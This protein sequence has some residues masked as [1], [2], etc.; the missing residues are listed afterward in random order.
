MY[1]C[2]PVLL[3]I[4]NLMMLHSTNDYDWVPL[5]V[6]VDWLPKVDNNRLN[7]L[8]AK[9][10]PTMSWVSEHTL[11]SVTLFLFYSGSLPNVIWNVPN[12]I[13]NPMEWSDPNK[14]TYG[15]VCQV[16]RLDLAGTHRCSM[17]IM[18]QPSYYH[19]TLIHW[20]IICQ[21][22]FNESWKR[23]NNVR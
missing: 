18:G 12:Q 21:D 23:L 20:E 1:K 2:R 13:N 3:A 14:A 16:Q 5:N 17:C 22:C 7:G 6:C 9:M 15:K 4:A 19:I 10:W 8:I 11:A